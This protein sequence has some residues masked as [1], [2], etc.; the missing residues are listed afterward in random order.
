MAMKIKTILL[1]VLLMF[2]SFSFAKRPEPS[3]V[4][5]VH[6]GNIVYSVPH[7][8]FENGTDQNGGSVAA[9]DLKTGKLLWQVQVYS[10]EY[11]SDLERDI[12]DVFI[13]SIEIAGNTL[14]IKNELGHIFSL[15]IKTKKVLKVEPSI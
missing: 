9:S 4:K 15:N 6:Y 1:V 5:P 13:S 2:A 3:I 12:Q 10:I 7:W 8:A 14:T 11:I